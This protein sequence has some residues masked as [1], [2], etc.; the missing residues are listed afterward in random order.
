[1]F[2]IDECSKRVITASDLRT[3]LKG[4]EQMNTPEYDY[5]HPTGNEFPIGFA[6]VRTS[7]KI[8]YRKVVCQFLSL[9]VTS[10]AGR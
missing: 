9:K 4:A 7:F 6:F 2:C 10:L 1:L 8:L 5:N 3:G